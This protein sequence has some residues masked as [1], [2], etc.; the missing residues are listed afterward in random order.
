M[1]I[2]PKTLSGQSAWRPGLILLVI[3]GIACAVL[4]SRWIDAHRPPV[5]IKTEEERLYVNGNM[6]RR[7]SLG[8]TGLIADWYWMRSLQYVGGKIL[9][10][11]NDV[12][13]DDLGQL[14]LKLLAPLLDAATTT[15]PQFLEPYEYA[16]VVLPA[17]NV[18]EAIRITRKG[19]EAN[20]SAWRLYQQLGYIYWQQGDFQA[21]SVAY[22]RGA[23]IPGAPPWMLA[24]KGRMAA[25][26]GSRDT[27][28]E[29][30]L[31]MYEQSG[32]GQV[33]EMARRRLLQLDSFEQRD[34]IR[35]VL[36][37]YR[38]RSGHCPAAWKDVAGLLRGFHLPL[39]DSGAPLDPAGTAYI[40]K[41]AECNV[42]LNPQS[43]VPYQ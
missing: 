27:A 17:V 28:R 7:M 37:A 40:L 30:Y 32:D 2:E 43:E 6:A 21:A 4:L 12:Q 20:P 24:M 8:F 22:G 16:A 13:I 41:T 31:R 10:V 18:Q 33:K 29:I 26:G 11:P 34:I 14:N 15:D 35:K 42:D 9:S 19:I 39:D 23:L 38:E 1:T 25:E 5:D 36:S 3:F